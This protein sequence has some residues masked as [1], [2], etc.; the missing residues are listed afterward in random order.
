MHRIIDTFN[1]G[2]RNANP[3]Y[4]LTQLT[5]KWA[6]SSGAE[7]HRA[8]DV[9]SS[10]M[11]TIHWLQDGQHRLR[12]L[13]LSAFGITSLPPTVVM[14]QLSG[15]EI[16]DLSENTLHGSKLI[17]LAG[18]TKLEQLHL[19]N[20]PLQDIPLNALTDCQSLQIL[21]LD[22]CELSEFPLPLLDLRQLDTLSLQGNPLTSLPENIGY[23]LHNLCDLDIRDTDI[24]VLPASLD[25]LEGLSV[26]R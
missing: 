22:R 16:L 2:Y 3:E 9:A 7:G 1:P 10:V 18:L 25:Y 19:S 15:L 4:H 14:Q 26:R 12:M 8:A 23:C 13:D 21:T 17:K 5:E 6:V 11:D 24:A 20:N